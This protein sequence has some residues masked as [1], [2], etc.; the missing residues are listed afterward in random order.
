MKVVLTLLARD[1]SDIVDAHLRYHLENGVD[2]VIATD[3][4][5]QD[6]TTE[7]LES[8]AREGCLHL[9]REPH[10]IYHQADWVTRMARLAATDFGADWVLHSDADEF[11]WPR[12]GSLRE[13]LEA[14]PAHYGLL[15]GL[16][17]HFVARPER[18]EPFWERMVVRARSSTFAARYWPPWL[19]VAHRADP[20]V[21]IS[22]GNH[23]ASGPGL[24]LLREWIPFE[25]FHLPVRSREQMVKKFAIGVEHFAAPHTRAMFA[26]ID[27]ESAE[28][29]FQRLV[30]GDDALATGLA[31]GSLALDTRLRDAL[32]SEPGARAAASRAPSLREDVSFAEEYD[33]RYD[34]D[35]VVRLVR[36]VD[37]FE[38]RLAAVERAG[39]VASGR[40]LTK[41]AAV[42]R[43]AL[44]TPTRG[45]E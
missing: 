41:A 15:A 36:H 30:V 42:A 1:E 6:G 8:Y 27:S 39:A 38:Q 26:E 44:A 40:M 10:H 34:S 21:A 33:A 3:N 43:R 11:W 18:E 35:S 20:T 28:T 16:W 17:R 45:R 32:R 31:D 25:I 13:V 14:V 24:V 7:I 12:D 19:K 9:I 2:F 29:T 4:R 37:A 23:H 22:Q 5:S